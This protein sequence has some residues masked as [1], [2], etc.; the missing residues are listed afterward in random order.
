MRME[1]KDKILR[2]LECYWD[3]ISLPA[4]IFFLIQNDEKNMRGMPWLFP[5]I[6]P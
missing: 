5:S 2:Y 6:T 3:E 4:S 1:R